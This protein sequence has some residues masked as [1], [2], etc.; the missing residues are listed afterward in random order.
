MGQILRNDFLM[1]LKEFEPSFKNG[2][3]MFI[4]PSCKTHRVRVP[5][6]PYR[7][8]NDGCWTMTGE[9]PNITV[10]PSINIGCWHKNIVEGEFK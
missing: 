4:C 5:I 10:T 8:R 7:D 9:L 3:L 2:I 1:Y 6:C